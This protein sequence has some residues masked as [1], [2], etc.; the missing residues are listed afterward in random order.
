MWKPITI[1]RSLTNGMASCAVYFVSFKAPALEREKLILYVFRCMNILCVVVIIDWD[2]LFRW[3]KNVHIDVW[4]LGSFC[5]IGFG[6][7]NCR[8]M[9]KNS[10]YDDYVCEPSEHYKLCAR[11]FFFNG[12]VRITFLLVSDHEIITVF[13]SC[14]TQ[15]SIH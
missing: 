14:H 4:W 2:V 6:V 5:F 10:M 15:K 7:E 12:F 8:I 1:G 9:V 13:F 11:Q 3:K